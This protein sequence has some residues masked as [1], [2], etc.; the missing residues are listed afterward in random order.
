MTSTG[1]P[2][3]KDN[4][5]RLKERV[6]GEKQERERM[7]S[8]INTS[9]IEFVRITVNSFFDGPQKAI[10]KSLGIEND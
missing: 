9:R 6:N 4:A 10:E 5:E 7:V 2:P 1:L 3:N 8:R